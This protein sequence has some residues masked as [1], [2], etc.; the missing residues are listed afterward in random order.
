M[1]VIQVT[2]TVET[3]AVWEARL[4]LEDV[5]NLA[6]APFANLPREKKMVSEP[7]LATM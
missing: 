2:E 1:L 6:N 4:L 7:L 3:K 5:R